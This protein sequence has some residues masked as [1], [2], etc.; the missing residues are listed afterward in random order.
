MRHY[1]QRTITYSKG[2]AKDYIRF[3][4]PIVGLIALI[5]IA[6]LVL[7]SDIARDQDNT[8]KMNTRNFVAQS[9]QNWINSNSRISGEYALWNDAY[10]KI[11]LGDDQEWM[12]NNLFSN[13]LSAIYVT[14]PSTDVRF[15]FI[16]P[17]EIKQTADLTEFVNTLD[18]TSQSPY[19]KKPSAETLSIAPNGLQL[20]DGKPAIIAAQPIRPDQNYKGKLPSSTQP[21][22]VVVAIKFIDKKM[23]EDLATSFG[24]VNVTLH[25]GAR[26]QDLSPNQIQHELISTSGEYLGWINWA[27]TKPGTTAFAKRVWPIF[28][29]LILVGFM[30]LLVT[31]RLLSNQV[32]MSEGAR[33]SA[34][35]A[36]KTKSTFLANVSHELRTPLNAIIGYSEMIKEDCMSSGADQTAQD[37][38]KVIGS[39]QHL[40][41][42]IN[43]LLDHSKIEAGKMDLNPTETLLAPL[44]GGIGDALSSLFT[45]NNSQFVLNV[46]P[47]VGAA[48]VDG[49]R[50]KQC[51]LNLVSN[52][53]KFTH[54]GTITLS[55]RPVE[56]DGAAFI[57]ISV[58][59]T[60]IG[61][62]EVTLGKLFAPFVQAEASTA[63]KFG[64]TG[65]GLVI[66]R[67]LIEAMGGSVSVESTIGKGSLF[68]I[69]L[70]RGMVW[71]SN[72]AETIAP[73]QSHQE[74]AA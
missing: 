49:M 42:L 67:A 22:D 44:F 12:A 59:D 60:G 61:M 20:I 66:T 39:A 41:G 45:K 58:K 50:L 55:A 19:Q 24:L 3:G 23:L 28:I 63:V 10:D 6:V 21:I 14:R 16:N 65:L 8:Y 74:I 48:M 43:D 62:N 29:G 26:T 64:G 72:G 38:G 13:N 36:S 2:R 5:G 34:E 46:D 37:A 15:A 17:S 27:D 54:N 68:T 57:R 32:A 4:W 56:R 33:L 35:E 51:L 70:P 25:I 1:L 52:A 31:Y 7:L 40:L 47:S 71:T 30:T 53:A 69:L 9:V 18:L 11:T 73:A